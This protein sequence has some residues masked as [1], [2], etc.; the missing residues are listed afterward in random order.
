MLFGSCSLALS[1]LTHSADSRLRLIK[2][3]QHLN[4]ALSLSFSLAALAWW[5]WC[6][7][8][9]MV[10]VTVQWP[11]CLL[12]SLPES[13]FAS[14]C[15]SFNLPYNTGPLGFCQFVRLMKCRSSIVSTQNSLV[16]STGAI[17]L[18][19]VSHYVIPFFTI[20][21]QN[22]NFDLMLSFASFC[23]SPLSSFSKKINNLWIWLFSSLCCLS[24][25]LLLL[26]F[27]LFL[28]KQPFLLLYV[29]GTFFSVQN[30]N[31]VCV[32][33]YRN[34]RYILLCSTLAVIRLDHLDVE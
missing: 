22:T 32:T 2:V 24:M 11:L 5:W 17:W 7:C 33:F 3:G 29:F 27:V 21:V 34:E 26:L 6:P 31:F 8:L 30:L 12:Q 28:Q 25:L 9:V 16:Q 20:N 4:V 1:V 10:L 13:V 15:A 14:L 18:S 23:Y 19:W